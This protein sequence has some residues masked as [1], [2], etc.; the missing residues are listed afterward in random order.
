MS[1]RKTAVSKNVPKVD[2]QA[3]NVLVA[4]GF[5]AGKTRL[6]K[7]VMEL[8]YPNDPEAGLL[9]AFEDGYTSWELES[10]I[11]MHNRDWKFFREVVVKNLVEEAATGRV[12]KVLGID[13]VDRMWSMAEEYII[14]T[15]TKK[16][17]KKFVSLQ[18]ITESVKELNGHTLT[19]QEVWTQIDILKKSGYG[20]FWLCW[21]KERETTTIDDVKFQSIELALSKSGRD[22]FESQAHLITTLFNEVIVTDKEGNELEENKKNKSG[23][24]IASKFHKSEVV[25]YFRPS[26]YI[27][28]G[29]GRFTDLPDKVEYSAENFLKVFEDAVKGQLKTTTKSVQELKV[30]QEQERNEDAKEFA[31]AESATV[32]ADELIEKIHKQKERFTNAQLTEFI[33][34]EFKKILGTASYPTVSDT[35]ALSNAVEFITNFKLPE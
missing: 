34:P 24:E 2:L 15:Y 30:E 1:W 19:K 11:D 14:E 27:S 12:S 13:T 21:T 28:I 29:G 9:L 20:F 26:N 25:M 7:E 10:I 33:V 23:K 3:Y 35:E 22:I 32:A 6:W 31:E 17:G 8:F 5:K 4:G 18:D 16:Y